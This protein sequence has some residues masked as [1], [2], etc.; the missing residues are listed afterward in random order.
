MSISFTRPEFLWLLLVAVPI[1]AGAVRLRSAGPV[2]R[3]VITGVRAVLVTLIILA[4]AGMEAT[5]RSKDMTVYFVLDQ[6]D[7]IP[8]TVRQQAAESIAELAARKPVDDEAGLVVFGGTASIEDFAVNTYEFTGVI[9]SVVDTQ[10]SD[11]ARALRLAMSAF[12]N[13]RM[14]RI[15]LMTDGNQTTGDG[16]QV[17]RLARNEGIPIDVLPLEYESEADVRIDKVIAPQQV[18]KDAPY[19]VRVFMS[20]D[21]D[22]TGQLR[23]FEDGQLV[24]SQPVQISA[25]KNAP[26][27]LPR[28][29]DES[30]FKRYEAVVEVAGDQRP[31]NNRAETFTNVRGDPRVL[32]VEGAPATETNYLAAA[33]QLEGVQV[34]LRGPREIPQT[35]EELQ[36]YDSLVLSNVNAGE[37]SLQQQ[38]MIEAAVRDLGLGL[39]MV[40]GED[41][42]G[43]GGYQD[44]P[45]ERALPVSM[46]V[47]QKKVLP[48]GALAVILHTC[49]FAD[50]NEWAR[51][52]TIAALQVLSAQDYLGVA[53][54]GMRPGADL[55]ATGIG[56]HWLWEPGLQQV[57]TKTAMRA[58]IQGVTPL[59]MQTFDPTLRMAYEGLRDVKAQAK[60]IVVISDGDP[61]PPSRQLVNAIRDEGITVTGVAVFPHDPSTVD[62]L[63]EMAYEGGGNFYYPKT[64]TELPRIFIKEASVVRRSLIFEEEFTPLFDAPSEALAGISGLRSLLGYVV[65]SDKDLAT[66]ALRTDKD[67]PLLAH[68]RYGLGKTVAFTSDAK[69]RWAANWVDWDGFSK[70]WSQVVRW[71]LRETSASNLQVTTEI[72]GGRGQVTIDALDPAGNFRNF[73]DFEG[74]VIGPDMEPVPLRVRQVGPGRYEGEFPATAVGSYMLRLATRDETGE[75]D[76][77]VVSGAVLSYSPEYEASRSNRAFMERLAR[78]SGG[79][80]IDS[81]PGYNAFAPT[82]RFAS[83]PRPVWPWLLLAAVLL[84][85]IDVMMRRVYVDQMLRDWLGG[86]ARARAMEQADDER[87]RVGMDSLRAAKRRA[88]DAKQEEQERREARAAFRDRLDQ[89]ETPESK[90]GSVFD[91]QAGPAAPRRRDKQTY[92][93]SD[94]PDKPQ[95]GEGTGLGGLKRAKERARRKMK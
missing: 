43:A 19:E 74:S 68:W 76:D 1:L 29:G 50:G 39:V 15:V 5:R 87:Q 16:V 65:T 91:P 14:R 33:L 47:K 44:S 58:K 35:L 83:R 51:R 75:V 8:A 93:A 28:R 21:R 66:V 53:Y 20:S 38:N 48:N 2:R 56:E 77:S 80:V 62:T 59:D 94:A 25:G 89:A 10:R 86:S 70:F 85:P 82:P 13:D 49:E 42:F 27:V 72:T 92:D 54:F 3:W 7:S 79:V 45:I 32:V 22:T 9:N 84:T 36:S 90:G 11:F 18:A 4:L 37:M 52:I 57:G 24:A 55:A 71:S 69:N 31:Q 34:S 64:P 61:A 63:R 88:T 12:P 6:S 23:I 81:V 60:H 73:L 41:S 95:H 40:G 78:E 17:A 30:G 26:L 67:D 46:D